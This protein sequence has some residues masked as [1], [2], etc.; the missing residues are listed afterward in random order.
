MNRL[1]EVLIDIPSNF[2]RLQDSL[3]CT[4][5]VCK[6]NVSILVDKTLGSWSL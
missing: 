3:N 5:Y 4:L 1:C 6:L 2:N